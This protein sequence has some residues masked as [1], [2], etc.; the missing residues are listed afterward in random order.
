M[1]ELQDKFKATID[2]EKQQFENLKGNSYEIAVAASK[3]AR[4]INNRI[5]K[6]FGPEVE[7][8]A[9]NIAMKKLEETSTKIIYVTGENS[10]NKAPSDEAK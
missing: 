6:Y 9:R 3:Y 2:Y 4:E 5:R 8:Q 10:D 1:D 7:A